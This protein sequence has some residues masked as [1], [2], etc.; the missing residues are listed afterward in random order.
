MKPA[1]L[2]TASLFDLPAAAD[3]STALPDGSEEDEE[4]FVDIE[5]DEPVDGTEEMDDAA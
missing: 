1:P 2:K 5:D 3:T 4:P